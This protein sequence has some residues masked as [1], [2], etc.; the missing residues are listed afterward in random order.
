VG[1]GHYFAICGYSPMI[2]FVGRTQGKRGKRKRWVLP[3][4]LCREKGKEL[5]LPYRSITCNLSILSI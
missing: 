2:C 4:S 1:G 3:P 5:F